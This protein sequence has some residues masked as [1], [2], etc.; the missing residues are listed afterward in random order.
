[1]DPARSRSFPSLLIHLLSAY[2]IPETLAIK[3]QKQQAQVLHDGPQTHHLMEDTAQSTVID[4]V[5]K[6]DSCP[7]G[8]RKL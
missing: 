3:Q 1:M 4:T 6:C 2:S 7:G 5:T 8:T